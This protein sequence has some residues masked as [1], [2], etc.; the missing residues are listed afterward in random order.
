MA[1]DK[2]KEEKPKK[3]EKAKEEKPVEE[4]AKKE[5]AKPVSEDK[6]TTESGDKAASSEAK[7]EDKPAEADKKEA[8]KPAEEEKPVEGEKKEDEKKTEEAKPADSEKSENPPKEGDKPTE[9]EGAKTEDKPAE[10]N[11]ADDGEKK[12]DEKAA[13]GEKKDDEKPA[14]GEK[15][16]RRFSLPFFK[17]GEKKEKE[18]KSAEKGNEDKDHPLSPIEAVDALDP[19]TS[20]DESI[21]ELE[22]SLNQQ[23]AD[24]EEKSYLTFSMSKKKL[25]VMSTIVFVMI[26]VIPGVVYG[27]PMVMNWWESRN[28]EEEILSEEEVQEDVVSVRVKSN[29]GEEVNAALVEVLKSGGY[30]SIEVLEESESEYEYDLAVV[31]KIGDDVL[32]QELEALLGQFYDVASASAELSDDSEISAL[33]Q[34][35]ASNQ[36]VSV[37]LE[38]DEG[39]TNSESGE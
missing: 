36:V 9:G 30:E 13:E 26:W 10:E 7:S 38:N 2:K 22:S 32:K 21:V 15:K 34:V 5:E 11:K 33:I 4:A 19:D 17:K 24:T 6:K 35:G 27:V 31:T 8:D 20:P 3:E 28:Q 16:A 12:E 37:N 14:D 1:E 18:D 23:I 29:A 39:E 25:F